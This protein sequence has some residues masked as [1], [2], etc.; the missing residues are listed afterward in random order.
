MNVDL[1]GAR[2]LLIGGLGFIGSN[3]AGRL[4][5]SGAE[6]TIVDNLDALGGGRLRNLAPILD[7]VTVKV[8]DA[9]DRSCLDDLVA[10]RDVVFNLAG[11]TSHIDSMTDP[12]GD[13]EA[14]SIAQ[15][16]ILDAVRD[17]ARP[18]RMIFAST[19]Q[20]YGR[21]RYLPVDENHPTDPVDVNGINK[22]AAESFHRLYAQLHGFPATCLRLTNT[23]GPRMR[24]KDAR[25]TFLGLWVRRAL[26]GGEVEV[27]GGSQVR[28]FTYVDD[29]VDALI[30]ACALDGGTYNLGG[31][32]VWSL[33]EAAHLLVEVAGRGRVAVR[34]FPPDRQSI[35]IGDYYADW[36]RF[37]SATGWC[38]EV[39]L[40]DGIGRTVG[41]FRE[42]LARYE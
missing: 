23:Y 16:Q 38:P 39:G 28:D 24:V 13:V 30:S 3:L 26:T 31:C 25:Q 8:V 7:R 1:S 2:T 5:G 40:R 6:V 27:W 10:G 34:D 33:L 41:Y 9:R 36:S 21:P 17:A 11:R 20:L 42:E 14:N 35:D 4:V 37:A 32:E 19:R 15:L 22:L 18:P 29:A 12:V